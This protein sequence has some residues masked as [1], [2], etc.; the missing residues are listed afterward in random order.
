MARILTLLPDTDF[1]PTE[2]CVPWSV[3]T[4]AGHDVFF[5]T[6]SGRA[7]TGD[8][9]TLTGQGLPKHLQ[10]LRAKPDNIKLYQTMLKDG[11]FQAPQ[12]WT[13]VD[14]EKY[15][16]LV[17]PG[18]HGAGVKSYLEAPA[19]HAICRNF[20][21][22]KAPVSSIC[23]G[24]IALARTMRADGKSMLFGYRVTGL[25]NFQEKLS[26]M[27]TRKHI[28]GHYQ[29]YPETVQN[30]VCRALET[31]NDFIP[32]PKFPAYGS[33]DAPRKGFI[34]EDRHLICGRWPGD[35]YKLAHAFLIKVG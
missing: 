21:E 4:G 8:P 13:D 6:N 27:L 18:G 3:L 25:T 7:A 15:A 26:I 12:A 35:A 32:G 22:R 11:R 31:P 14:P 10:S 28:G 19:V 24:I 16:A 2:A 29:T 30:E 17:L 9:I 20:F 1:D 5:A 33:I 34:V 23:H